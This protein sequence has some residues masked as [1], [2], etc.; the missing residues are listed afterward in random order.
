VPVKELKVIEFTV[1]PLARVTAPP[2]PPL[3][4]TASS[5]EVQLTLLAPSH[6]S[7]TVSHAPA[8]SLAPPPVGSHV[9]VAPCVNC[10]V[11]STL[12]VRA[13]SVLENLMKWVFIKSVRSLENEGQ[14]KEEMGR[15]RHHLSFVRI[16]LSEKNKMVFWVFGRP[17]VRNVIQNSGCFMGIW[18]LFFRI[19]CNPMHHRN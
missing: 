5:P 19:N 4:K 12:P 11:S 17:L 7:P 1:V 13:R 10:V 16:T 6:Q 14:E 3:P 15:F 8:P 9:R 2:A 18:K